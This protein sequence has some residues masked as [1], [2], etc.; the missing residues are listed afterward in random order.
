MN[1]R[2]HFIQNAPVPLTRLRV[3]FVVPVQVKDVERA[4]AYL[5]MD[6]DVHPTSFRVVGTAVRYHCRNCNAGEHCQSSLRLP[7]ACL[8]AGTK[9]LWYPHALASNT[10][11]AT[12]PGSKKVS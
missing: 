5:Q 2:E 3:R 9:K 10:P 11:L 12:L 6:D 8:S 4:L 7:R 1:V